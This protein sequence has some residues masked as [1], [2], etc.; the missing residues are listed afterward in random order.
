MFRHTKSGVD[1]L[2]Q[3]EYLKS[4]IREAFSYLDREGKGYIVREEVSYIMKY[5]GQY[6][7]EAQVVDVILPEIQ[8][9]EPTNY[10][11][12]EKFEKYM[13]NAII[14]NEFEPDDAETLLAAFKVLDSEGKGYIEV[15]AMKELLL[16]NGIPFYE[17]EW[18]DFEAY[19]VDL[20]T[21]VINYEDYV[22]RLVMDN[23]K[24]INNL[25]K[26]LEKFKY[27]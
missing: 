11:Y 14:N 4:L 24:H 19:S 27:P 2:R 18:Q 8:E 17:K 22:S 9:D 12:Y 10:V 26:G 25:M 15:D 23:E 21:N 7:S 20:E 6:P 16:K 3:I 1:R 5:F 13:L